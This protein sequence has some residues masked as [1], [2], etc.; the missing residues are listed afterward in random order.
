MKFLLPLV[1][2]LAGNAMGTVVNFDFNL[3]TGDN[4]NIGAG[5]AG[6]T[7][8]GWG[9]A[10][11][12]V[13]NTFWNSVR[14]TSSSAVSSASGLNNNVTNGG[15]IRDSTGV[16]SSVDVLL[17]GTTGVA[18][19]T[20]IGQQRTVGQQELGASLAYED[21]MGDFLQLDAPGTDADGN[22]GTVNG[23]INGLT[24]NG[25][26]DLYFYGQGAVYGS[27]GST[28]SGANSFFAITS[29]LGGPIVGSG[30]QTSWDGTNGGDGSLAPGVE[31]VKFTATA[32]TSGE[33]FFIW[34]NVRAGVNVATDLAT[35]G[36]GGASDLAAF[37][38]LQVVSVP[39]PSA[40]L[41]GA[42]GFCGLLVRRHR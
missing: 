2:A 42:L 36:S 37:N 24:A 13:G 29:S 15:P 40:M 33:I 30:Q 10:P 21:L 9:A 39:E 20:T 4:S 25:V 19:T 22:L 7:Y 3:N 5:A 38:A 41:L 32:N 12:S 23:T 16:A 27:P 31:Y 14:R 11:D 26:Y 28:T 8:Q 34:Q 1:F 17:S 35:D 18:G 6:D